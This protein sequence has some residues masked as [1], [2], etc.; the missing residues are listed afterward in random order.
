MKHIILIPVYDDW[1]SLN[2]LL[3]KLKEYLKDE[4]KINNEVLIINDN[5]NQEPKINSKQL[6]IFKKISV[7][8]L[9]RNFGSQIAIAIGLNYLKDQKGDFYITVMDGDGED[10][11]K[12]IKSMLKSAIKFQDYVITSN[13][14]K[15]ES[16]I[17]ICLYKLH[18]LLTFCLP[19]NGFLSAIFLLLTKNLKNLLSKNYSLYAHSSAVLK[20]CKIKRLYAMREK[21]FMTNQSRN[22][23]FTGPF[24]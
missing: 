17:I 21:D 22:L 4:R 18:L 9:N 19:L 1:K 3:L 16:L 11:P 13:R 23:L 20:N 6:K 15:R 24:F 5:S 10:S 7:L 8:S 14:K 12:G 2:K